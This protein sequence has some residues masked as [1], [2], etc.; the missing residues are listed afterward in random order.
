MSKQKHGYRK[1]AARGFTLVELMI[2]IVIAAI[3]LAITIPSYINHV[4]KARRVDAK[5]ALLDL[6]GREERFFNTNNTYSSVP[7]D[8]GYN[9]TLPMAIGSGSTSYYQVTTIAVTA[10]SAGPPMVPPAYTITAIPTG[11]QVN[12]A[13]CQNFTLYSTGQQT[14]SPSTTD[15]W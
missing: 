2:V 5:T 10:G 13:P 9:G 3:L 15:C 6:A 4:R 14:S 8:L 12:D 7:S 11:D 1:A